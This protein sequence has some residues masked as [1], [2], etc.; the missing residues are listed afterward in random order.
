M[1]LEIE[2][3]VLPEHADVRI[4]LSVSARINITDVVAQRKVS[5]LV[6]DLV[7]TQLYGEKPSLVVGRR[8]VWRVPVWLG[9][10]P[11][12]PIAQV[13][14]IDVDA[15]SGEILYTQSLLDEL[16]EHGDALARRAT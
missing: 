12:G 4:Q 5:K 14:V 13:G 11:R 10:P 8:L 1:S 9:L 3:V 6:L 7:G 15:Q 2:Q 16:A